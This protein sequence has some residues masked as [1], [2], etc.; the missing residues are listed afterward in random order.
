VI[1]LHLFLY[2]QSGVGKSTLIRKA[3]TYCGIK[4]VGFM[5]YKESDRIYMDQA[6]APNPATDEHHQVGDCGIQGNF[7]SRPAIFDSLGTELLQNI[8]HHST[9]LMD[10]LGFMELKAPHFCQKVRKILDQPC[11]VIGVIKEKSNPFLDDIRQH[12]LVRTV[13]LRRDNYEAV[14][15]LV[16]AF[17][18][19]P[20]C[21]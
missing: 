10:E 5:T 21:L 3:L 1:R 9:V 4:P 8:P 17:L 13:E 19:Q 6:L 15:A 16:I 18:K 14:L 12:P 7:S 2:G 11:Q 20:P